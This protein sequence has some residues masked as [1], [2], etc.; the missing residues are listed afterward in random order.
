MII[1]VSSGTLSDYYKKAFDNYYECVNREGNG[2]LQDEILIPLDQ[3]K[4][5][6]PSLKIVFHGDNDD[7]YAWE[8]RIVLWDESSMIGKYTYIEDDKGNPLDE[9]LVFY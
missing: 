4:L 9:S 8:V 1:D 7:I 5:K 3:V 6:Y 2:Y